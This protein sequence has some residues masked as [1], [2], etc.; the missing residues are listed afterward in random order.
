MLLSV[1]SQTNKTR[2]RTFQKPD[3]VKTMAETKMNE[4]RRRASRLCA[5]IGWNVTLYLQF[6]RSFFFTHSA[7]FS[8]KVFLE[9]IQPKCD[10]EMVHD[11]SER[12]SLWDL[13]REHCQMSHSDKNK[14]SDTLP[15]NIAFQQYYR[16]LRGYQPPSN[17]V[18][19]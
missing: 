14:E 2:K 11:S 10:N 13:Q 1:I 3:V 7:T 19:Q 6:K 8:F 5:S 17:T 9:P 4:T 16:R 12:E 18:P 15:I